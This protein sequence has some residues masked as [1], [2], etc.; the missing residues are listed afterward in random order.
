MKKISILLSV[1]IVGILSTQVMASTVFDYDSDWKYYQATGSEYTWY[2]GVLGV[3]GAT[4]G[5]F[6]WSKMSTA[7]T[8]QAAFGTGYSGINTAWAVNTGLA[9]EKDFTING[10]ISNAILNFEIDNGIA[11]FLNGTKLFSQNYDGYY[12]E[13]T[14]D[15]A[16]SLFNDGNNV[17]DVLAEDHG[18]INYVD[19]KLTGQSN[20]VPE[21]ATM[22]LLGLGLMG[23][24]GV[25]RKFKK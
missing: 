20:T 14:L 5:S 8:G 13:H 7:S 9:L 25:R 3:N 24:A 22:L 2:I 15:I 11:I 1:L 4:Y 16:S 6:D 17:I 18:V 10:A 12:T 19:L 21:P 23:L